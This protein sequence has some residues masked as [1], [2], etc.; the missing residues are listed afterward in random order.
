MIGVEPSYKRID[1]GRKE[2]TLEERRVQRLAITIKMG[3]QK[4]SCGKSTTGIL[5]YLLS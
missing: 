4:G 2:E 3:I 5:G 1:K